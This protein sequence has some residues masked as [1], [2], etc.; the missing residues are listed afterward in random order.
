MKLGMQAG[1]SFL[2]E[3]PEGDEFLSE[4]SLDLDGSGSGRIPNLG[5]AILPEE[6]TH[7]GPPGEANGSKRGTRI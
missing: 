3:F 4:R 1:T 5:G 7:V 2:H 6:K